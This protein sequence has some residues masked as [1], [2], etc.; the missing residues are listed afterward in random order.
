MRK[1]EIL[2]IVNDNLPKHIKKGHQL[3]FSR[4]DLSA[5]EADMFALMIANMSVDD[6]KNTRL[7]TNLPLSN[8]PNG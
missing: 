1:K 5:R 2:P 8:F 6:W 4:Q 7:I 3:V